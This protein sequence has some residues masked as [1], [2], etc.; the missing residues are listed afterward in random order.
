MRLIITATLILFSAFIYIYLNFGERVITSGEFKGIAIGDSQEDAY[1]KLNQFLSGFKGKGDRIFIRLKVPE[2][3]DEDLATRKGHQ[4]WIEP[5][6]HS[7][8]KSKYLNEERWVFY[9]NANSLN[10]VSLSFVDGKVNEIRRNR[11]LIESI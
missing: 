8:G 1:D 5:S 7:V 4:I 10:S 11:R 2:C 9:V 6:F 3:A